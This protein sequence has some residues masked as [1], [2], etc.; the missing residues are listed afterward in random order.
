V[1]QTEHIWA[2]VCGCW[3]GGLDSGIPLG[4]SG[5][6]CSLGWQCC[7]LWTPLQTCFLKH[8][9]H[10]LPF[11][12]RA[13]LGPTAGFTNKALAC[14]APLG[15]VRSARVWGVSKGRAKTKQE[16]GPSILLP[17]PVQP[18]IHLIWWLLG[19][20][21]A[22]L[23]LQPPGQSWAVQTLYP[24]CELP[25]LPLYRRALAFQ[26]VPLA[27]GC[28]RHQQHRLKGFLFCFA[29]LGIEP[30]AFAHARQAL[31]HVYQGLLERK[32]GPEE[33]SKLTQAEFL[34]PYAKN[35]TNEEF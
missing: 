35:S 12:N 29:M 10:P 33:S 20:V 32:W 3:D 18:Q 1:G 30:R 2:T 31:S 22:S 23:E 7:S 13:H 26:E 17:C 34:N 5:I 16:L 24:L 14:A 6:S 15:C 11:T 9:Q 28:T 19:P 27:Q 21:T 25:H 8:Q 4:L